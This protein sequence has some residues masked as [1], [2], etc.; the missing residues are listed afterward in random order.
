M[1][2]QL[3]FDGRRNSS[4]NPKPI[5]LAV[6]VNAEPVLTVG[7]NNVHD[8][9]LNNMQNRFSIQ[10]TFLNSRLQI[11]QLRTMA[12][13]LYSSTRGGRLHMFSIKFRLSC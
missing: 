11:K 3:H 9:N 4:L 2:E 6:D 13:A 10:S 8:F 1:K 5:L 12:Q 7:W